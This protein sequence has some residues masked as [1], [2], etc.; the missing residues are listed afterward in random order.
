MN[1][2]LRRLP[3]ELHER[4]RAVASGD[5]AVAEPRHAATVVLL[6]DGDNGV[7][8]YLLR[9]LSSMTF[10]GGMYVF[11]GG[12]VDPRDGDADIAW[13]GPPPEEWAGPL[14]AEVRLARALVAAAVRE[15]FEEAGVLLASPVTADADHWKSE[16]AALLDRS[17]TISEVLA[18][19]G[20]V[21]RADLLR[22]WAHWTTP[23]IE[24]KRFDTR[25][26]V[27]ALPEGQAPVHFRGESDHS[28]WTTPKAAIQRHAAGEI[29][30]LPPTVFTLAEIGAYDTVADV[31]AAATARDIKRVLP[32]IVVSGDDVLLLLPGDPGYPG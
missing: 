29:A 18:R 16:Q 25:F 31:M 14:S 2:S 8:A 32:K 24:P 5:V 30:M 28:E 10:A 7:E 26:F 19:N 6:R 17:A 1:D 21:L 13:Q 9:R 22:P 11:P 27:A 3:Q 12:S 4:A 23:E 20:L 15:T